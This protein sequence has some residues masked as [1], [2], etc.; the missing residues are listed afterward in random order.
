M[1][2]RV[3]SRID[4]ELAIQT[5][6]ILI[7]S[8]YQILKKYLGK[9]IGVNFEVDRLAFVGWLSCGAWFNG[10]YYIIDNTMIDLI[11]NEDA[12]MPTIS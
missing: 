1:I 9:N 10:E 7:V 3:S 5:F 11:Y 4:F 6:F 8:H 2:F 12:V